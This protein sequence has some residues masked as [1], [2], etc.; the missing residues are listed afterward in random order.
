MR[1][2]LLLLIFALGAWSCGTVFMWQTAI[3]NF[4]VA[5]HVAT[6]E[7]EGLA[8]A[9]EGLAP[10]RVREVVRYQASEV[11]R[12][13]FTGWGWVQV[14]LALAAFALAAVSQRGRLLVALI[15]AMLGIVAV[16]SGYVVPETV[17]LG[18]MIDFAADGAMPEVQAS[19]WQLHHAYTGLD[20]LKFLIGLA[21]AAVAIRGVA[22]RATAS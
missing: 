16:L 9:V 20:M 15:G 12:L 6:V 18:R 13:F 2:S 5:E 7:N 3:K 22:P 8:A 19:F 1:S 11:N 10:A 17:R 14:P 21:A 4:A